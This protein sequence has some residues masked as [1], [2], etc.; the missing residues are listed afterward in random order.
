MKTAPWSR[1]SFLAASMSAPVALAWKP[2][3]AA[4]PDLGG[5]SLKKASDLLRSKAA[6]PVDLVNACLERIDR[7]NHSL[8]AFVTVTG[9]QALATAREM[10]AEQRRG[11]WRG[12]LHGIPVALKDNIDTAGIRTTAASELFKERTPTEDAEVV[13]RLETGRGG[14]RQIES[15]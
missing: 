14:A 1:R 3:F 9:D 6:T 5:L 10:G 7:Y 13:R 4:S 12:P 2:A 15:P 8:N 11:K